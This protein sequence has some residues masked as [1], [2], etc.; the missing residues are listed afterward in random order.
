M[1]AALKKLAVLAAVVAGSAV[2]A[3]SELALA[4][5]GAERHSIVALEGAL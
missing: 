2:A 3:A 1:Q 4:A 5:P